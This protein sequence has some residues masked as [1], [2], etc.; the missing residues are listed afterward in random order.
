MRAGAFSR[1][2]G[3]GNRMLG[4]LTRARPLDCRCGG[5]ACEREL[6][7]EVSRLMTAGEVSRLTT[8]G[9][10]LFS[11]LADFVRVST[12]FSL[13]TARSFSETCE[14]S[15]LREVVADRSALTPLDGLAA[16]SLAVALNHP[17][18]PYKTPP[19]RATNTT[20]TI[21][22]APGPKRR[23]DSTIAICMTAALTTVPSS[24]FRND[25]DPGQHLAPQGAAARGPQHLPAVPAGLLAQAYPRDLGLARARLPRGGRSPVAHPRPRKRPVLRRLRGGALRPARAGRGGRLPRASTPSRSSSRAAARASSGDTAGPPLARSDDE[26]RP[27]ASN[28]RSRSSSRPSWRPG[29]TCAPSSAWTA[30]R[31]R[32]R[33]SSSTSRRTSSRRSTSSPRATRSRTSR[34]SWAGSGPGSP[35]RAA[36]SRCWAS[37]PPATPPT[38]WRRRSSPTSTSSRRWPT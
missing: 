1:S 29:P 9:V 33:R 38:C 10:A 25:A 32:P 20:R 4:G 37:A 26:L 8:A 11:T 24:A 35:S 23:A 22:I 15:G 19:A 7:G 5:E 27:S 3:C 21:V 14:R 18:D 13:F 28:T 12:S 31:P 34:R 6:A 17:G 36:P 2:S 30:A 16:A